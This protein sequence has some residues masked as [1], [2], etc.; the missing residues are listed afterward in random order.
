MK[1]K[2]TFRNCKIDVFRGVLVAGLLMISLKGFAQIVTSVSPT[3]VTTKTTITIQGTGFTPST[4][5]AFSGDSSFFMNRVV[6]SSSEI[7]IEVSRANVAPSAILSGNLSVGG[8]NTGIVI[9]YVPPV[10]KAVSGGSANN[11]DANK[12]ITEIFTTHNGFWRSSSYSPSNRGTWPDNSHD[13]LG[14]TY[15]GITYST[16]V[17]DHLLTDNG[18]IFTSQTFKAYSTNGVQGKT[19]SENYLAMGDM[20]DGTMTEGTVITSPAILGLTV[21]DV[22]TDGVN[23]LDLGTGITNFNQKASVRFYSGNGQVGGVNDAIPDLLITQIADPGNSDIYYYADEDGNVMGNPIKLQIFA[24]QTELSKWQLDLYNMFTENYDLATPSSRAFKANE[25]RSIRMV[26]FKLDEFGIDGTSILDVNNL[27]MMAGGTADIAFLAYNRA[28]FEIKSPLLTRAPFSRFVCRIPLDTDPTPNSDVTFNA[29]ADIDGPS[30]SGDPKEI[31]TYKWTKYNTTELG[32]LPS[33]TVSDVRSSDLATYKLR[34]SNGYGSLVVPVT[35]SQGGTPAYWDGASWSLPPVY[36]AAGLDVLPRDRSLVFNANYSNPANLE[37]CDCIVLAGKDVIIN[38]G[39]T[40]KLYNNIV[41]Q[42]ITNIPDE[43]GN[44]TTENIPAGTFTLKDNAS[45]IQINDPSPTI[46]NEGDIIVER[47]AKGLKKYDYVYWSS[48]VAGINIAD[49]PGTV[50]YVWDV[51]YDNTHNNTS[52][53]WVKASGIMTAGKGYIV[54]VTNPSGAD[55]EFNYFRTNNFEG[56]PNNG[57]YT[58]EVGKSL[59]GKLPP[60]GEENLNLIGN[61]YPSAI[62]GREFVDV[63]SRLDGFFKVW[64]HG[65]S[66]FDPGSSDPFYDDFKFNYSAS[67]YLVYNWTASTDPSYD[68]YIASGQ[69]FFVRAL[70]E[71]EIKFTN[72]MRYDDTETAHDNTQFYRVPE[73]GKMEEGYDEKQ[74]IWL[75]LTNEAKMAIVSV[76]GYVDG[77]TY[78]EDRLYDASLTSDGNFNLYSN[79]GDKRMVIQ[80]RPLPFDTTD[81]VSLGIEVPKNGIY[82]I[83]IDHLKGSAMLNE[84]QGIYLEDTYNNVIHNLRSSPY[85]FTVTAGNVKD[86]FVLRYTD[87]QLSVDDHLLSDTFVY[88]KNEQLSVKASKMIESVIVYDLTGKKLMDYK[89]DGYSDRFNT[90]FQFPKGA[91]LTVIKLENTGSVT[92][93]VMN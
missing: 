33:L 14:F 52:G 64:T 58:I 16:G 86:R 49:L 22:I 82:K 5:V 51:K 39:S 31:L 65:T 53:N 76:V 48:P 55:P 79:L 13:L 92:K 83:G 62:S 50:R 90:P 36:T 24:S 30:V 38:G 45:L 37:G 70:S 23:G 66:V 19:H 40:L 85:S 71:G 47:I 77:A 2:I 69:S 11:V 7:T 18:V 25:S 10:Y 67:D 6:V 17:A 59:I 81:Q 21:Y 60:V 4:L 57:D 3:R 42:P 68:G 91:Y 32:T 8:V 61:P 93:K 46:K 63:N 84:D 56:I 88:V 41:V 27:N 1:T 29:T 12:K 9:T 54:R 34:I 87:R 74:L 20:I 75:S 43:D 78:G 89:L 35:L 28:A 44:P 72:A 26:A 73:G 80:G 15:N